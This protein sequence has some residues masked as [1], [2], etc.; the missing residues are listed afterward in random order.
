MIFLS[1]R[2]RAMNKIE[3]GVGGTYELLEGVSYFLPSRGC[4]IS[5]KYPP[6]VTNK[7]NSG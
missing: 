2:L 3:I 7:F 6:H 4:M 1:S 5:L